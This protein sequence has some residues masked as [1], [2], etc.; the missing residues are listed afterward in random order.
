MP[1]GEHNNPMTV[2]HAQTR[3]NQDPT[4]AWW[5]QQTQQQ[6]QQQTQQS[7]RHQ[8]QQ[9]VEQQQPTRQQQTMALPIG[10]AEEKQQQRSASGKSVSFFIHGLF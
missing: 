7:F 4:I 2:T 1:M 10:I 9:Q 6:Q 8:Y 5:N 3:P